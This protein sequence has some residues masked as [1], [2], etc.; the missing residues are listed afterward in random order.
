[1]RSFKVLAAAAVALGLVGV[2]PAA[3][4]TGPPAHVAGSDAPT[5][6]PSIVNVRVVRVQAALERATEYVD[7][8]QADK[9]LGQLSVARTQLRKAWEGAKYNVENAPPPVAGDGAVGRISGAP[10]GGSPYADQYFTAYAVISLQ[11]DVASTAI[12]LA[13]GANS[14][15]LSGLSTTIF[16]TLNSRDSAIAYIHSK[17]TAPVGSAHK[18]D[19]VLSPWASAMAHAA[20]LLDDEILQIDGTLKTNKSAGLSK[21]LKAAETQDIKTQRTL[22]K[23][24][25]PAPAG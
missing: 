16:S 24:W 12:G 22:N 20:S 6:L 11:H 2:T 17:D 3:A 13:D 9:A 19:A 8:A 10:V 18:S 1:M 5:L 25:P 21:V 4:A 15:L 23:Y 14:T 7:T